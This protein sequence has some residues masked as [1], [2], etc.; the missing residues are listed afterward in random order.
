MKKIFGRT[1][2][3]GA[4]WGAGGPGRTGGGAA[5]AGLLGTPRVCVC[6][7]GR[8]GPEGGGRASCDRERDP[9]GLSGWD[10]LQEVGGERRSVEASGSG[11]ERVSMA[12][13]HL[14]RA[15]GEQGGCLPLSPG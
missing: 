10:G 1:W 8:P 14:P 5:E 13:L 6:R 11:A 9:E 7:D 15:S 2:R 12:S 4:A 3:E